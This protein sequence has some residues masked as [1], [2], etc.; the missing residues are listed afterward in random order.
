VWSAGHTAA[1][2][3]ILL[4]LNE[5]KIQNLDDIAFSSSPIQH[6]VGWFDVPMNKTGAS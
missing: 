4:G 3:Q 5:P 2:F 1:R 6:D